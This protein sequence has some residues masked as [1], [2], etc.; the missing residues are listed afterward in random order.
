MGYRVENNQIWLT[1]GDTLKCT[2][3]LVNKTTGEPYELSQGDSVRFALKHSR[4]NA[5]KTAYDDKSPVITKTIPVATMALV[6][7]PEDTSVLDFGNYV[8]DVQVTFADESV[9]TV[10]EPTPFYLTEEVE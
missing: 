9:D 3:N 1:R 7:D 2:I 5:T 8:Y 4:M 10:I 6:L